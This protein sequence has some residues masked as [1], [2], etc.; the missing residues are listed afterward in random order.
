M[1]I[2]TAVFVCALLV[3][4]VLAL[5]GKKNA[6]SEDWVKY[7]EQY[8]ALSATKGKA[9]G[10][11]PPIEIRQDRLLGYPEERVDRCRSC[12]IALD[13]P[14]FASDAQPLKTHPPV[15]PHPFNEYG[16]TICHEGEGRALTAELAHGLDPFW[17]EP[18]LKGATIQA[19]CARCHPEPYLPQMPLVKKGRDLYEKTACFG[20]HKVQGLSR[21]NLGIELTDVGH[22]RTVEFL[23]KKIKD[24][25]GVTPSTIM[26]KLAFLT[27][28]DRLALA[29]FLKAQKG[30]SWA[31]DAIAH[32]KHTK[33]FAAAKPPEAEVSAETGKKLV[34]A[35]GCTGCHKLGT[36][37]GGLAADLS[38]LG[39]VRDAKYVD[40]HLAD[41]R[42][43]SPG[44]NMPNFWLSATERKA[45]A[46]YL[47]T[48]GGYSPPA[49][50]KDRY[51][52]L[53]SRC[54]GEKGDGLGVTHENLLPRPRVFTNDKFFNW[55]PEER[56][57][58]AIR[59]GVP[60]TAMP[61]FGKILH[62]ED[63]KALFGW[64][65]KTF[66]R[67][68]KTEEHKVRKVPEKNPVAYSTESVAR[69]KGVFLERCVG[70]HGRIGDG[71]G[72]NAPDML[73][74]PRNLTNRAF[75][76]QVSDSRMFESVT[77][78][79]VGTGMPPWVDMLSE[80]DRWD[81]VNYVRHLSGT[82]PA[83]AE[84]SGR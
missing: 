57:F 51:M 44:S 22:K 47:T 36:V 20:C 59:E 34:D 63:A 80:S 41:P 28:D 68:E 64:I 35:R 83:A 70:C 54:H 15:G 79:I 17:P 32:R 62:E 49:D 12:H 56:A 4:G 6:A 2:R 74:R 58:K 84:R 33:A 13:D 7:Q 45:M 48:L 52:Q 38:Y 19:S 72:P 30:K 71:K 50:Q 1:K 55:L 8:R 66:I 78:G 65:R 21:G 9:P 76:G 61:P 39:Q 53:C 77:Y 40:D 81:L 67:A 43:H 27:D 11:P 23:V 14:R 5:A 46:T 29:T 75:F 37:D 3:L 26:P 25:R 10:E 42:A 73:P 24:P 18:L 16:C 82:G 69:A 31:E 60:G